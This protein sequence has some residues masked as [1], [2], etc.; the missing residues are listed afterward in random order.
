MLYFYIFSE[1]LSELIDSYKVVLWLPGVVKV[2][3]FIPFGK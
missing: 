1:G 2:E 3:F